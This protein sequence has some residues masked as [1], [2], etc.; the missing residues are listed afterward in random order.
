MHHPLETWKHG[1]FADTKA[2]FGTKMGNSPFTYNIEPIT[3]Y[4]WLL[5]FLLHLHIMMMNLHLLFLLPALSM[6]AAK[7]TPIESDIG[8]DPTSYDDPFPKNVDLVQGASALEKLDTAYSGTTV[9]SSFG[10]TQIPNRLPSGFDQASSFR[11]AENTPV[12][13]PEGQPKVGGEEGTQA[14]CCRQKGIPAGCKCGPMGEDIGRDP[15]GNSGGQP[16]GESGGQSER[17][18]G[19][20]SRGKGGSDSPG[21]WQLYVEPWICEHVPFGNC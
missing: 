21:I 19:E 12:N 8:L 4:E 10:T 15:L 16:G 5:L 14:R 3:Y 7:P 6:T 9:A 11:L 18:P 20:Q 2:L 13:T 1:S 17:D